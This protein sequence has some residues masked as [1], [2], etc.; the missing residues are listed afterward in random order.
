MNKNHF[1]TIAA[2]EGLVMFSAA[3][4]VAF[5][6]GLDLGDKPT[7]AWFV[8]TMLLAASA[9]THFVLRNA[10]LAPRVKAGEDVEEDRKQIAVISLAIVVAAGLL[11]AAGPAMFKE[12]MG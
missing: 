11:S 10:R 1:F 7:L 3:I 8:A 2:L 12:L 5:P 9:V 6:P 4:R